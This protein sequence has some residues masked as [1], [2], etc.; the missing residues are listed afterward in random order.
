MVG[1][2]RTREIVRHEQHVHVGNFVAVG[3]DV[4]HVGPR[5]D[6]EQPHLADGQ[7]G[8]LQ[9]LPP[10]GVLHA[11]VHVHRAARKRPAA[12]VAPLVQKDLAPPVYHDDAGAAHEDGDVP[13]TLSQNL[14]VLVHTALRMENPHPGVAGMGDALSNQNFKGLSL[15]PGPMVLEMTAERM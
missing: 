10:G 6:P 1:G 7:A 13:S 2:K 15:T 4:V 5:I 9:N 11:L 3:I 14:H 8:L 12:V